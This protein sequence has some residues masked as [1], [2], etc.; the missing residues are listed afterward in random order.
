MLDSDTIKNIPLGVL[1]LFG[2]ALIVFIYV[3]IVDNQK[4]TDEQR[5]MQE[6]V[7][8]GVFL[9]ILVFGF[10]ISLTCAVRSNSSLGSTS[11]GKTIN[12]YAVQGEK[13][14]GIVNSGSKRGGSPKL[15]S[16]IGKKIF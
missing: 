5:T 7:W 13:K 3:L 9:I 15:S 6:K 11:W 8:I 12:S 4:T 2:F 10:L 14:L 1:I 16:W